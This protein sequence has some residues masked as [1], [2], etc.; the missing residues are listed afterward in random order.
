MSN[1]FRQKSAI[2]NTRQE[3]KLSFP[4]PVF[5]IFSFFVFFGILLKNVIKDQQI[6]NAYFESTDSIFFASITFI[7]VLAILLIG[8]QSQSFVRPSIMAGL[9]SLGVLVS[10]F[11][12]SEIRATFSK[13]YGI[14][15]MP[16]GLGDWMFIPSYIR[17]DDASGC[18][19]LNR[20][21]GYGS[22]WKI[23][24]PL[25]NELLSVFV[26]AV[27][28]FYIMYEVGKFAIHLKLP[29]LQV[30]LFF[31]PSFLFAVERGNADLF[32]FG[33]LLLGIRIIRK[34]PFLD[35]IYAIFLSTFK[36]F[37]IG[38][39]LKRMPSIKMLF[40]IT[41]IF[42]LAY[43]WSMNLDMNLI[44]SMRIATLY[45]PSNQIGADQLP[46][47]FLQQFVS[48]KNNTNSP[49]DG[50]LQY[51]YVSL[52]IGIFILFLVTFI[53]LKY[54][55]V[56]SLVEQINSLP[57]K[58]EELTWVTMGIFLIVFLSGSQV[59][60]KS[61]MAYPILFVCLKMAIDRDSSE[62]I[63]SSFIAALLVFGCLGVNLW[64]LRNLGTLVL[65][66]L[67]LAS[68]AQFYLPKLCD[69]IRQSNLKVK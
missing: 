36:P 65:A 58:F 51:F 13:L 7:P 23:L 53:L 62:T 27:V 63:F 38:Y 68:F 54:F 19:P 41:P 66:A 14:Y 6:L 31:S 30:L 43:F 57:E 10:Y 59:S 47:Y 48:I 28:V 60:Y 20:V 44:R 39:I 50:S 35:L 61:W 52:L 33:L 2:T 12:S 15:I 40:F 5:I 32:I 4:S 45:S 26:L 55:S 64:V 21:A 1:K 17:C 56:R 29:F 11:S 25:S 42:G 8:Y 9:A 16:I 69:R 34:F 24:Y 67:C 46:S 22:S 37:F 18:D 3:T 49:W